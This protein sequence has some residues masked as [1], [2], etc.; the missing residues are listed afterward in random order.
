MNAVEDFAFWKKEMTNMDKIRWGILSTGNIANQFAE[1]LTALD[2]ATLV[3]V[4][5]R[6]QASAD[7]FG[8]KWN[9]P[10]RHP[11]YEALANDPDI[12]AIYISTPHPYHYENTLLCLNAGKHVLVEKPFAMNVRQ[13][14]AMIDLARQKGLFLMEAM[15]TRYLPAMVLVRKWLAEG[16]IGDIRLVRAHF[17]FRANFDPNSRLFAPELGGG[18]LLDAGI[19]PISFA[20]MVLGSPAT[21]AS[22]VTIGQTGTDDVSTYLFGYAGG[23]TAMLSSGVHL[24][25]PVEAE[26]FGSDGYIKIHEPWL[27]PRVVTLAKPSEPGSDSKLIYDGILFDKQTVHPPTRGNGYNYEAAE[28]GRCLRAGLRE[29][30]IMPLDETLAIMG[31]LDTLRAQWSLTYPNE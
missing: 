24:A 8:D 21:I 29:S 13:T 2:D 16:A 11:S 17:S 22:T 28:V 9:V 5:S 18:A 30:A 7:A 23:R 1:G 14:R 6:E 31:T 3:A 15:W 19:Y 10:H 4:G 20:H 25:I 27:R 26:I 12:D